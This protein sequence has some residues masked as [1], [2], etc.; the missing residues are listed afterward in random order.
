MEKIL[1]NEENIE[2]I[3]DN[4]RKCNYYNYNFLYYSKKK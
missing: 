3:K 4:K 2:I 1:K